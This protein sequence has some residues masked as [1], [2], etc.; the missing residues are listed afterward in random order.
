[1]GFGVQSLG[2]AVRRNCIV[3]RSGVLGGCWAKSLFWGGVWA[4]M[5]GEYLL[6]RVR[7]FGGKLWRAFL[8]GKVLGESFDRKIEL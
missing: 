5:L 8:F 2:F 3:F 4:I 1:M 7:T 6:L